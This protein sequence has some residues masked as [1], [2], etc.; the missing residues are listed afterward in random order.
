MSQPAPSTQLA[1]QE[2]PTVPR[3]KRRSTSSHPRLALTYTADPEVAGSESAKHREQF[4]ASGWEDY[5]Y[6]HW[7]ET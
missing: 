3:A 1:I 7:K 6:R 4:T 5:L 2:Q